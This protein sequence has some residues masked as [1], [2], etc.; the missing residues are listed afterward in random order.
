ML[1]FAKSRKSKH[2]YSEAAH[3][4]SK[5]RLRCQ[6][7]PRFFQIFTKNLCSV[8]LGN[9]LLEHSKEIMNFLLM[10]VC[11]MVEI[12]KK[13]AGFNRFMTEAVII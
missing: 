8:G 13:H 7:C 2:P 11:E 1:I 3:K 12:L 6:A 5:G 4:Y 10:E 9:L